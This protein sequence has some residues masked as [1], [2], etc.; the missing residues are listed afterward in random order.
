MYPARMAI[1]LP[2]DAFVALAALGWADDTIRPL[3]RTGLLHAAKECGVAEGEMGRIEKALAEKTDLGAFEPGDM[4]E[5][6]RIVT[7]A[8][9]CWLAR[10]DGVLSTE[11]RTSLGEL[12]S[13]LGL[14]KP[15]CDRASAAAF[16]ISVLPEGGRPDRFDF[17]KLEARLREKLPT[18]AKSA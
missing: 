6:Q 13:R 4:T 14:D 2:T 3:E 8:L 11:E 16:D 7:Y 18:Q 12:A 10:L 17:V 15:L 5:W 9:A 1:L